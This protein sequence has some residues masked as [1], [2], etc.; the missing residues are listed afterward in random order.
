MITNIPRLQSPLNFSVSR[1][2][3]CYIVNNNTKYFAARQHYKGNSLLQFIGNTKHFYIVDI[4]IYANNIK[5]YVF[6]LFH[7]NGGY[8][9]ASQ[10][11]DVHS[12]SVYFRTRFL[13]CKVQLYSCI[14]GWQHSAQKV[15]S[16][17]M[18]HRTV[19]FSVSRILICYIV[20]NNTK[21]FAARQHCKG[22]S[23][24]QSIGNT[25]HFYIV[26]IYIY[27]NNIKLYVFLL[28]HGNGGYAN[29]SHYNDVHSL[30]VYFRTNFLKCKV[31]LYS[32]ILGWQHSKQK[33]LSSSMWHRTVWFINAIGQACHRPSTGLFSM[34]TVLLRRYNYFVGKSEY[35]GVL[36]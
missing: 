18:W 24:L 4:Y 8:A 14:L 15:L 23:L 34:T 19:W 2:L 7:G 33:V 17:S 36:I 1:I 30:S 13:K 20:N 32:C 28:F 3:I 31:Q 9:N 35:D 29:A 27:A 21:Y 22:N 11:N 16:S 5:L 6:L 12:L 26:D 10:Y 25:K